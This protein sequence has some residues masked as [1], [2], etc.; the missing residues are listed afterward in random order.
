MQAS[1]AYLKAQMTAYQLQI[2][3]YYL[4][5]KLRGEAPS[6][7]FDFQE[8]LRSFSQMLEDLESSRTRH[9][10]IESR[11]GLSQLFKSGDN[12]T[13]AS[14]NHDSPEWQLWQPAVLAHYKVQFRS[15]KPAHDIGSVEIGMSVCRT[16]SWGQM[17]LR[18]NSLSAI[19][20]LFL[21]C[22]NF[23]EIKSPES[24]FC[25]MLVLISVSK[26]IKRVLGRTFGG[27]QGYPK[28][29]S[30]E[31]SL[32]LYDSETVDA[33]LIMIVKAD[34]FMD[35]MGQLRGDGGELC[36]SCGTL[37][38]ENVELDTFLCDTHLGDLRS[39]DT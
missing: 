10:Q 7:P 13:N 30:A 15:Q 8:W 39:Q 16:I 5:I 11:L 26:E 18:M 17:L 23:T 27:F 9:A 29:G 36:G 19:R 4:V 21:F 33:P 37:N 22:L 38:C 3:I 28:I 12:I 25:R 6:V 2:S 24:M 31:S 1:D 14:K 34:G 20:S 35:C 32:S